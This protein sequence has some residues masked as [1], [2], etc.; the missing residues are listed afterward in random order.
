VLTPGHIH[1]V[2]AQFS[3]DGRYLCLIHAVRAGWVVQIGNLNGRMR[4]RV[5][6]GTMSLAHTPTTLREQEI[7]AGS[8]QWTDEDIDRADRALHELE[9]E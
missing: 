4:Y 2:K 9:R 7:L 3:R 6:P 1:G 5:L 8:E